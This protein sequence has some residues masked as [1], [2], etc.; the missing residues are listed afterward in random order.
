MV[1]LM[2]AMRPD[3]MYLSTTDYIQHK[4]A[5]GSEG[6]NA[7]YAMMDGYLAALDRAGAVILLTADHGMNAKH[8]ADGVPNVLYLQSELDRLLGDGIARTILPITD[9]YVVHHGALG[10]YATVYL[11]A[12]T[13]VT[14]VARF[15]KDLEGVERVLKR[16]EAVEAF[17][18][19]ADRI[20]DLVVVSTRHKTIGTRPDKHDLS[21]LDVPLR[22]HGGVSEQCVPLLVNRPVFGLEGR[23]LRNFDAFDIAL[24]H[25]AASRA[26]A[27]E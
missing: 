6:A 18:L 24:N 23:R 5:P 3:L 2:K 13:E 26:A 10:S 27:A 8:T 15:I 16:A 11:S 14:A 20:G 21:G 9:P 17:E 1:K 25:A 12:G 22:S 7:F 19:P 4:H